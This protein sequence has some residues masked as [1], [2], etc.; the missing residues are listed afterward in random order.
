MKKDRPLAIIE[1]QA[2]AECH[3]VNRKLE[4][5]TDAQTDHFFVTSMIKPRQ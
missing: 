1:F 3:N 2:K 4:Y 5:K